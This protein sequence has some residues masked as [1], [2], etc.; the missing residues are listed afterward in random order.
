MCHS[1]LHRYSWLLRTAGR[2]T[3]FFLRNPR[4]PRN[5]NN[6][7]RRG[8]RCLNSLRGI[9]VRGARVLK[10]DIIS[11]RCKCDVSFIFASLNMIVE[12]DGLEDFF[13]FY[14]VWQR[15]K[16]EVAVSLAGQSWERCKSIVFDII[17]LSFSVMCQESSKPSSPWLF[18]FFF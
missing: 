3:F 15:K 2:S 5:N 18:F 17:S 10:N 11:L 13:F 12:S 4:N 8:E 9:H 14:S 6:R 16:G 7:G 1:S